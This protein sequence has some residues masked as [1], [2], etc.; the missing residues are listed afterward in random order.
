MA[1]AAG[2]EIGSASMGV[3]YGTILAILAF[4]V[5]GLGEELWLSGTAQALQA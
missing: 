1:A 5:V 4:D 3:L 2:S